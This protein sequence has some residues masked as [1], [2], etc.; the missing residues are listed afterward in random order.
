MT[1]DPFS[2]QS[3]WQNQPSEPV[4]LSLEEIHRRIISFQKKNRSCTLRFYNVGLFLLITYAFLFF[5]FPNLIQRIG[6]TLSIAGI[7]SLAYKMQTYSA[8]SFPDDLVRESCIRFYRAELERRR[9]LHSSPSLWVSLLMIIPGTT[10]F[11]IAFGIKYVET[12]FLICVVAVTTLVPI[13][14]IF[15][16]NQKK[17]QKL[18]Q[19]IDFLDTAQAES[20]ERGKP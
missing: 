7:L 16:V 5:I 8:R 9:K 20:Q 15:F 10:L 18:Q 14:F 2:I 4:V 6:A 13:P 1:N 12:F 19:E 17:V 3:L 11:D